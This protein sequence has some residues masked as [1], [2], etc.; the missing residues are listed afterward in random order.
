MG[1]HLLGLSSLSGLY[2][3][4]AALGG[5]LTG[6]YPFYWLNPD[7]VGSKEAVAAYCMGFVALAPLSKLPHLLTTFLANKNSVCLET[8]LYRS[9]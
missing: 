1:S 5:Y 9:A 4:W 7:F 8:R 6:C 2:L 3:G